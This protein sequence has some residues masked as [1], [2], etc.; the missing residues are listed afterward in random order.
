MRG[1]ILSPEYMITNLVAVLLVFLAWRRPK[2]ATFLMAVLFTG[3]AVFNTLTA[4]FHPERYMVYADL[5]AIPIYESFIGGYFSRNVR[6]IIF[7]IAALQLLAGIF[8]LSSR[9]LSNIAFAGAAFFLLAIA[10]LGA[11]SAFPSSLLF[12]AA[13]IILIARRKKGNKLDS[14]VKQVI[15]DK[16]HYDEKAFPHY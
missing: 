6:F 11:G 3:A 9:I 15:T 2:S 10:P 16:Q 12:A 7:F 5:A 4:I 13:C 14:S 8:M 1:N